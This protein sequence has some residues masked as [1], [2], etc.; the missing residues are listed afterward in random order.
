[1]NILCLNKLPYLTVT[2]RGNLGTPFLIIP[3]APNSLDWPN[4]PRRSVEDGRTLGTCLAF[5]FHSNWPLWSDSFCFSSLTHSTVESVLFSQIVLDI[6]P[7]AEKM[8]RLS[9]SGTL[10]G[11]QKMLFYSIQLNIFLNEVKICIQHYMTKTMP[12]YLIL[13]LKSP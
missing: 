9:M 1:M 6:L 13:S 12:Y 3:T 10:Y 5:L 4:S 2:F 7:N 11:C 8:H